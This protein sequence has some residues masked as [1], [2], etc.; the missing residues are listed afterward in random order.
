MIVRVADTPWGP[1]SAP[2]IIFDPED[3]YGKFIHEPGKDNLNDPTRDGRED[4][5]HEYGPY[6]MAPYSTGV[7]GRYTKIYFTMS[8]WNPYQVMQMSAILPSEEEERDPKPYANDLHDRN[9]RK[10]AHV[11][12]LFAHMAKIN[13]IDLKKNS[14]DIAA[15]TYIADH[16]EW[17]QFHSS[18]QLCTEIKDK[19]R[20]LISPL[21][22]DIDKAE[23]YVATLVAVARFTH[24]YNNF[25]SSTDEE[26]H[27]RWALNAIH[28][29]HTD[30]LISEIEQAVDHENFLRSY[31]CLC[32]ASGPYDPNEFKYA[33]ITLLASNLAHHNIGIKMDFQT[34]D[35]TG[36]NSYIAWAR[37]R[38]VKELRQDLLNKIRAL[39]SK[40][41][42][43][44][45]IAN[46]YTHITKTILELTERASYNKDYSR[47]YEL[48]LS[49]DANNKEMSKEEII[50]R[51]SRLV[52]DDHFLIPIGQKSYD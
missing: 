30:W 5:G 19:F 26:I 8:T 22:A 51:I 3:G 43:A 13:N 29:G 38:T 37:F 10:Y 47:D 42:S 32:Y 36:C 46:A 28:S 7:K 31:D 21:S 48:A 18:I 23:V 9:D 17:A 4:R 2:K 52:E 41:P 34:Q 15:S 20:R 6:Q 24:D 16:L 40:L 39:I 44:D 12:V 11:S 27:K 1:W 14:E 49:I 25:K 35:S 50:M 33:R 45:S